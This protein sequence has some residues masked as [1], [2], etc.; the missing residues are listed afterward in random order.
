MF[1]VQVSSRRSCGGC[2]PGRGQLEGQVPPGRRPSDISTYSSC[3]GGPG[4]GRARASAASLGSG[5]DRAGSLLEAAC[6]VSGRRPPRRPRRVRST[7]PPG[8]AVT[9]TLP[10]ADSAATL[11]RRRQQLQC[12]PL[13][14]RHQCQCGP[15]QCLP[16][17]WHWQSRLGG[18]LQSR[19]QCRP[20]SGYAI[21][22]SFQGL[23]WKCKSI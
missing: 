4:P 3:T 16:R 20:G 7:G 23:F 12:Q 5:R 18:Y 1:L 6:L 19:F 14:G 10:S 15:R 17:S 22:K 21:R 13:P 2:R 11:T 9:V 8:R